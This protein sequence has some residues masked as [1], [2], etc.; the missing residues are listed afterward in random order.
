MAV[1]A[2]AW[3][4]LHVPQRAGSFVFLTSPGKVVPQDVEDNAEVLK[5]VLQVSPERT[6]STRELADAI[7]M[8]KS[9]QGLH[10]EDDPKTRK[11]VA[12]QEAWC[13]RLLACY[14]RM[15]ARRTTASRSEVLAG[16][17]GMVRVPKVYSR[18]RGA[19]FGSCPYPDPAE[20]SGDAADSG[21]NAADSG[22]EAQLSTVKH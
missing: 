22:D 21:S 18:S 16:L 3:G 13:L 9:R 2:E 17:K 7:S 8:Y 15:Q 19:D 11:Q 1:Y 20:H 10:T 12:M 5:G 14:V 4:G 6:P